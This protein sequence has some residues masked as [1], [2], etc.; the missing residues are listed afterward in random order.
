M[1]VRERKLENGEM[2]RIRKPSSRYADDANVDA[3]VGLIVGVEDG[4]FETE[5]D[6]GGVRDRVKTLT[7]TE[8]DLV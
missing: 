8:F 7:R 3:F 6:F 5:G 2:A 1:G 4:E